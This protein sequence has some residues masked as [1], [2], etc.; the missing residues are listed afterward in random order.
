MEILPTLRTPLVLVT[1]GNGWLGRRVVRALTGNL[2]DGTPARL[3]IRAA[4]C[5]VPAGDDVT[6]LRSLGVD[7]VFGDVRDADAR[8]ALLERSAGAVML[9]LAGVIHPRRVA[10]FDA[11]NHRATR[12]LAEEA[13]DAGVRR[14][15][16]MSSNS[17]VGVNAHPQDRFDESSPYSPYM[18]Y[19]R[20]KM[21]MEMALREL[22]SREKADIVIVRAPWFYGPGQPPRQTLF[23]TMIRDGKFPTVGDG[24]NRRSM[25][26]VDDLARGV[27]LAA[28]H[29]AARNDIFWIADKTPYAMGDIIATVRTVLRQ[30]FGKTVVD[31]TPQLPGLVGTIAEMTDWSLQRVGIYHQKIHV[32][33]EMNK[34]IACDISKAERVLGYAAKVGLREGMR[35][36]IQWCIESGFPI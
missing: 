12:A 36:S 15:V 7:L 9:H 3:D 25:A 11:I 5:L 26:Y 16:A 23:F 35:R 28:A 22:M 10:D 6:D 31:R 14:F 30:H 29:P 27:I 34:T 24:G 4:R 1:G 8:R 13:L 21:R 33:S 20:S 2:P 17:P 19:G 18:G 32:L